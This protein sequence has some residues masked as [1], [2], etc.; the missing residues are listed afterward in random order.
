[1]LDKL[2]H[3]DPAHA[4]AFIALDERTKGMLGVVRLHD[5]ADGANAEFAILV[6]SRLKG[7][8]I[9]WLLMKQMIEFSRDKGLKSIRGQVLCENTMISPCALSSAFTSP[10]IRTIAASR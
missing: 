5:D 2:I 3:Y 9:G 10:K 7:H 6:R 4:M 1:L 8:G